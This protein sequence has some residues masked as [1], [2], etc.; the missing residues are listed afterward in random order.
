MRRTSTLHPSTPLGV[1]IRKAQAMCTT[2][3][4]DT[5]SPSIDEQLTLFAETVEIELELDLDAVVGGRT[6]IDTAHAGAAL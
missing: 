3:H 1:A 4:H 5:A 6:F 2:E